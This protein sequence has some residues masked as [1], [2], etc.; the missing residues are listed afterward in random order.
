MTR[1]AWIESSVSTEEHE[2][3][4]ERLRRFRGLSLEGIFPCSFF[5]PSLDRDLEA[6]VEMVDTEPELYE[7]FEVD[8]FRFRSSSRLANCSSA[9]PFLRMVRH[10]KQIEMPCTYFRSK[11][12]VTSLANRGASL[13]S[14][15]CCVR[16]GL[17][18]YGL[19]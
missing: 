4:E 1:R 8:L 5:L 13:G 2:A 19:S 17:E 6:F 18:A 11:S 15:S 16:D 14:A 3:V 7:E 9:T 10:V 12:L